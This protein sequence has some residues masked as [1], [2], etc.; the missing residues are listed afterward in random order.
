[1]SLKKKI[2]IGIG[3]YLV[4]CGIIYCFIYT[5]RMNSINNYYLK[6]FQKS[7]VLK[8]RFGEIIKVETSFIDSFKLVRYD[9]DKYIEKYY[10]YTSDSKKYDLQ[11]I[12]YIG[13]SEFYAYLI[14][15]ELVF[16]RDQLDI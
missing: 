7:E 3:I 14:D 13:E 15:N 11:L 1:M 9:E 16:E 6:E 10:I 8:Q 5:S 4:M 2:L 12:Y